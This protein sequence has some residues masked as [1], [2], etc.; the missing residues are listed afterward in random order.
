MTV[1]VLVDDEERVNSAVSSLALSPLSWLFEVICSS[2]AA[3]M[4]EDPVQLFVLNTRSLQAGRP[5]ASIL[6]RTS[7]NAELEK[8]KVNITEAR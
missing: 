2:D 8:A 1:S 5:Q 4:L 7:S 6:Q 3:G